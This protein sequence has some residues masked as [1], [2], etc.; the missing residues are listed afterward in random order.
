MTEKEV[1]CNYDE[2]L[3]KAKTIAKTVCG[4]MIVLSI[5]F[6]IFMF[7]TCLETQGSGYYVK[8]ETNVVK[9]VYGVLLLIFGPLISYINYFLNMA[10]VGAALDLKY[11]RNGLYKIENADLITEFNNLEKTAIGEY[12]EKTDNNQI[13]E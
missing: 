8:T 4:I 9:I 11:I 3:R 1:I 6:A 10:L 13:T 12:E 7:A 5:A 2:Y